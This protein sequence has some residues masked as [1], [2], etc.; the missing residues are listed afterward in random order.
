MAICADY[1]ALG[2]LVEDCLPVAHTDASRDV[3]LLAAEVIELEN[4]RIALAAV[5]AWMPTVLNDK[6]RAFGDQSVSPT[7]RRS[8]VTL[9]VLQV[10]LPFV[11]GPARAAVRVEFPE[12]A[13][14]PGKLRG[15]LKLAATAAAADWIV[16]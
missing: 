8:N 2:D 13:S 15:R 7:R 14:V 3:E 6:R 11:G 1:V 9:P 12:C 5:C 10:V 16:I 4:D